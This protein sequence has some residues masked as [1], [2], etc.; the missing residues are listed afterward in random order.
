[1]KSRVSRWAPG[2]PLAGVLGLT[3]VLVVGLAS[4]A[5]ADSPPSGAS[6]GPSLS[7]WRLIL[8]VNSSGGRTG[9]DAAELNPA[10]L[11]SP[12]LTRKP[13]GALDFWAPAI[14]ATTPGS[15][16]ARTE[17]D[18]DEPFILG[19]GPAQSLKETLAVTKEPTQTKNIII[20]Q[21]F[22]QGGST[23]EEPYTMLHYDNGEIYVYTTGVSGDDDLMSGVPL[24]AKFATSITASGNDLTFTAAYN[25]K[26]ATHT[27]QNTAGFPGNDVEW[28]AGDYEQD[29]PQGASQSD[30][31][32]VVMY[33][34]RTSQG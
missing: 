20:A 12:W 27:I 13:G 29:V 11:D 14:G 7:G 28:H 17:L 4:A 32:R 1:M 10:A 2:V 21:L 24:G 31:G 25:G 19:Q 9:D 15:L 3:S 18:S 22:E 34:L 6:A 33:Q 5:S 26:T 23:A 30:G 16:H 8:P